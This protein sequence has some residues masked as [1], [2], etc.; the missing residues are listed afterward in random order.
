MIKHMIIWKLKEDLEDP[1]KRALEIKN[2]LE[3]LVGKI[4]G[5]VEMRILTDKFPVSTGD[6]LMD[7]TFESAK[8]LENYQSHPLHVEI[9]T[10]L[11]RSSVDTRLSFD[12]EEK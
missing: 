6:I 8:A 7:S 10:G 3:G 12:Y 2:A 4:D 11:V 1:S 9:A 5:L